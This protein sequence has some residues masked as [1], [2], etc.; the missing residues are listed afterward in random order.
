MNDDADEHANENEKKYYFE[1]IIDERE[2]LFHKTEKEEDDPVSATYIL[3]LDLSGNPT[4]QQRYL[5]IQQQLRDFPPPTRRFYL[6][7]NYG[8]A[9]NQ[10]EG[11]GEGEKKAN[12]TQDLIDSNLAIFRHAEEQEI[13]G[14]ILILEDDF[15]WT[16][17]KSLQSIRQCIEEDISPWL[18]SMKHR[19]FIY[20][21]GC[22]PLLSFVAVSAS[23]SKNH[24]FTSSVA[25]HAVIYSKL[26]RENVLKSSVAEMVD[27]DQYFLI[28]HLSR[29]YMYKE[30]L[31]YQ[32]FPETE[33]RK[34]WGNG[35][36][37]S[38]CREFVR[39]FLNT[40]IRM[41]SLDKVVD[42]GYRF[43][44]FFSKMC[45]WLTYI[46]IFILVM[47]CSWIIWFAMKKKLNSSHNI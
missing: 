5:N 37:W 34:N 33:N 15:F 45:G 27:W 1:E 2:P 31:V 24:Y 6:V 32:T 47:L 9:R 38:L 46:G 22:I 23:A 42:P 10:G 35:L 30:P 18:L 3:F 13:E 41:F 26:C 11:E 16:P 36:S 29:N 17:N 14:N 12:P 8:D 21:L 25:M 4:S 44:Y 43:F 7:H 28:H 20:K 39:V 40:C 19:D